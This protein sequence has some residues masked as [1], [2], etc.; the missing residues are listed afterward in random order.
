L[1]ALCIIDNTVAPILKSAE[2][3]RETFGKIEVFTSEESAFHILNEQHIDIVL[4]NLDIKPNDAIIFTRE[5]RQTYNANHPFVVVYAKKIEDFILELAYESG[6]DAVIDF[7]QKPDVLIPF[8][9]NLMAR[10]Q[11]K[12]Q[13]KSKLFDLDEESFLIHKGNASIS[14]P[15]KEFLLFKLLYQTPD[16]F[17]TKQEI[18]TLIWKDESIAQKRTIDVH[19]YNIRKAFDCPIIKTQKN[20]GYAINKKLIAK[21]P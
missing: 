19:V 20:R 12:K 8:L 10:R 18:A 16:K 5:L 1:S 6:V 2:A 4:V 13:Q 11:N 14:L 15:R 21:A 9:K 3:I 17:F 7:H